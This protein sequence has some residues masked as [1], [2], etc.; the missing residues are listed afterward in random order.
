MNNQDERLNQYCG[1][2][3]SSFMLAEDRYTDLDSIIRLLQAFK[4]R[5]GN[6]RIVID[7]G[8][9]VRNPEAIRVYQNIKADSGYEMITV[10]G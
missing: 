3:S 1:A 9:C 10:I 6:T 4:S 2:G 5:Y 7:D 8:S